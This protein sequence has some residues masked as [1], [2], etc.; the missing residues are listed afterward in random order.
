[1]NSTVITGGR[2]IDPSNGFDKV[3]DLLIQNGQVA[4][5]GDRNQFRLEGNTKIIDANDCVVTPGLIDFH[6]HAYEHVTP[7]GINIDE[8]CLSRGVTTAVDAGSAG[9]LMVWVKLTPFESF[10]LYFRFSTSTSSQAHM[11]LRT[12]PVYSSCMYAFCAE[13]RMYV[14]WLLNVPATC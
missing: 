10:I 9:R 5:I 12:S 6:V 4:D 13:R 2:I 1:M 8:R 7:L 14:C 11:A 3:A